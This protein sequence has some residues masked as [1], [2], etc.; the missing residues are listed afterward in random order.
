MLNKMNIVLKDQEF[1]IWKKKEK[2]KRTQVP[3]SGPDFALSILF[4]FPFFSFPF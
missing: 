4:P 3:E 2:K 1:W